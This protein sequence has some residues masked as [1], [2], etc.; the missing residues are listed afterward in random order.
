LDDMNG[1]ERHTVVFQPSGAR[2]EVGSGTTIRAAAAAL[3]VDIESICGDAATCGKC[4]VL[5]EEGHFGDLTSSGDHASPI[6]PTEEQWIAAR[7]ETWRRL[8][9]DAGR[10]RLSCQAEVRGDMVVFVPE[11]SRGNRQIIRKA[12]TDRPIE[13]RPSL[14]SYYVEMDPPALDDP[15]GDV[16]RLVAGLAA[17]MRRVHDGTDVV[18]PRPGDIGIDVEV[19]RAVSAVVREAGWRVSVVVWHGRQ[20]VAVKPGLREELYGIALDVGST[21]L[22]AYLC[23]LVGGDVIASDSMMNPQVVF[24]D[25]VMSRIR[26]EIEQEDGRG[27]LH[28]SIIAGLNDLVCRMTRHAGID[29]QDVGE[30]VVVGNT[31]MHHFVLGLPTE[32]LGMVPFVPAL[33]RALD[34]GARDLDLALGPGVNVHV[35]PVIAGFIGADAVAVILAEEPHRQDEELLIIDIGTNAELI[36]GNRRGLICTSTPT[37]PAFEGA[38]IEYGMRATDGAIERIEID[39]AT[40]EPRY[41]VIGVEGWSPHR[42]EGGGAAVKGICG[43]AII[44]GVAEMYRTGIISEGGHFARDLTSDRIRKGDLGWEYVVAR[45]PETTIGRDI[46]ITQDDVRQ[47]QL[48]KAALYAA[49][50]ILLRERGIEAPDRIVLAGA[51][52]SQID[53]TKAMILGL[54]PDVPLERVTSVG[55]AAGDGARIALLNRDKRREAEEIARSIRRV[56]LPIDEG[57]QREYLEAM[58]FPHASHRFEAI[59]DLLP[60]GG[61]DS[62][63]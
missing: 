51:F 15:A 1:T 62:P 37:G 36:L 5:I 56:E 38:H 34:V 52:G 49:A 19:A 59:A 13:I 2:G 16:D 23:D 46:P 50:Q 57:F 41:R 6:G 24:G 4:R 8:G 48:A 32:Q 28:D 53:T 10:L 30:L 20:V 45:A 61:S 44:D 18:I 63:P 9:I 40:L 60:D 47:I 14:R 58:S 39:A 33:Q 54:I 3:G 21:A 35:L 17:T 22:A 31:A 42:A 27:M 55:N 25:D 29:P 26:Q 11:S 7:S 12:A 43:S